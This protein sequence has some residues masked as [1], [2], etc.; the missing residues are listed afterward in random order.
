MSWLC[1]VAWWWGDFGD[2]GEESRGNNGRG[3]AGRF[4]QLLW[5]RYCLVVEHSW[6]TSGHVDSRERAHTVVPKRADTGAFIWSYCYSSKGGFALSLS[7]ALI[8]HLSSCYFAFFSVKPIRL[9]FL[10]CII[11]FLWLFQ[12]VTSDRGWGFWGC[13]LGQRWHVVWLMSWERATGLYRQPL[14]GQHWNLSRCSISPFL[15]LLFLC[16]WGG[17]RVESG[18]TLIYQPGRQK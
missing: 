15:T 16:V 6:E 1:Y 17:L 11:F 18:D 2:R 5:M 12:G 9:S 3:G 13:R 4:L 8:F 7:F 10:F 14:T